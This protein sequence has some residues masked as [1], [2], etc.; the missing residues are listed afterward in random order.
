MAYQDKWGR[1][2]ARVRYG[3]EGMK[4]LAG[5]GGIK[6]SSLPI[7]LPP[8]NP[9]NMTSAEKQRVFDSNKDYVPFAKGK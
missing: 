6:P 1:E 8:V 2:K 7:T 4:K 5:G 9:P 3:S